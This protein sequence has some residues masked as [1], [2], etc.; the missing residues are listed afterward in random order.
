M[1]SKRFAF[2]WLAVLLVA[3]VLPAQDSSMEDWRIEKFDWSGALGEAGEIVI[4]NEYG[5]IRCRSTDG[6]QV[7]LVANIQRHKDDPRRAEI[8]VEPGERLEIAVDYPPD[9]EATGLTR[10]MEKRRVDVSVLIPHGVRL[11]AKTKGGLIEAKGLSAPAHADSHTGNIVL[12]TSAP[13]AAYTERG[14]I[15]VTFSKTSWGEAVR[16]ETLTGDIAV[17]LPPDASVAVEA[18]TTGEL[19]TDFSIDV[20]HRPP[21]DKKHAMAKIGGGEAKLGIETEKG[22]VKLFRSRF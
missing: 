22:R 3:T 2:C 5:D 12:K 21:N 19:S 15:D 17:W 9:A 7:V 10:E 14:T 6:D 1:V 18:A 11:E 20:E 13:V 16:L 8:R 4:H